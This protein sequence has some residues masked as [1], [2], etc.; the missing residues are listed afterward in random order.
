MDNESDSR[1]RAA[2]LVAAR[3]CRDCGVYVDDSS[4]DT[5]DTFHDLIELAARRI[6]SED[7]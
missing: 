7:A 4:T 6:H 2:S 3:C 1:Y 5:H